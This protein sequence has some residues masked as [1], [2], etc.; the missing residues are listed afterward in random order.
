VT[1]LVATAP[2][3][4]GGDTTVEVAGAPLAPVASPLIVTLAEPVGDD[5]ETKGG[6]SC[7]LV[8]LDEAEELE[9][10][11]SAPVA[12][13]WAIEVVV[14]DGKGAAEGM[15]LVIEAVEGAADDFEAV[16][17]MGEEVG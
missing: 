16:E 7:V 11:A 17:D 5:L 6:E 12:V 13:G 15:D 14:P 8:I 4:S 3:V 1:V 9:K 2:G 10:G